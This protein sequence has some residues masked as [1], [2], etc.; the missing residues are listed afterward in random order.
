MNK[1]WNFIQ[2]EAT[3]TQPESVELRICGEIMSDDD[4]WIYEW[5]GI[6]VA[7]P[8]SFR[9]ALSQYKGKDITVWIDSF[10]GDVFAGAGIYNALKEHDGKVTAKITIAMSAA[11]VIAMAADEILMSPVGIMMIHNPLTSA[12]GDMRVMRKTADVLDTVKNTIINAYVAKTGLNES[13]ISSMMDDE[14]WMSANQAVKAKFA[15]GVLY[16]SS[17]KED[18]EPI[19]NFTFNRNAIKN[20]VNE[21]LKHFLAFNVN[22][23][24]KNENT[25]QCDG[26]SQESDDCKCSECGNC[27]DGKCD[28][29]TMR[30]YSKM[31]LNN[32]EGKDMSIK[33]ESELKNQ[34]PE[35]HNQI[36]N[37]GNIEGIKA[38]RERLKA[39][40]MLNGKVDPA[41]L[42]EEKYKDG[43]TAQDVLFRAM[44]EG[45]MINSGFMNQIEADAQN[46]NE[47]AGT[48]SDNDGTDEVTGTLNFVQNIAKKTLGK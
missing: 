25:C 40:D 23:I 13:E 10:G 1:F 15:D 8:N 12:Q 28:Q 42:N 9:N 3:E 45:K 24:I 21:S 46:A 19:M 39:F 33:N 31:I 18:S 43:A 36:Y 16:Q 14:T 35:I 34:L 17:N 20:S 38:E 48:S 29:T 37:E 7:S 32:K 2:N 22:S 5:F 41:F 47:V 11:S 30:N 26:C 4:S 6:P 44:Q 27:N